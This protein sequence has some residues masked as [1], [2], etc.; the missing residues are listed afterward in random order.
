MNKNTLKK[1]GL[2]FLIATLI[3]LGFM[4]FMDVFLIAYDSSTYYENSFM[5]SNENGFSFAN[6][7]HFFRGF[8]YPFYVF[9]LRNLFELFS[10][11]SIDAFRVGNMLFLSFNLGVIF[12]MLFEEIFKKKFNLI[13]VAFLSVAMNLFYNGI[14]QQVL[15]DMFSI[16]TFAMAILVFLKLKNKMAKGANNYIIGI[17]SFFI[18]FLLYC[19]YNS[20]TI[21]LY[22]SILLIIVILIFA[23]KKIF[24]TSFLVI[25]VL[26]C[27]LPQIIVNYNATDQFSISPPVQNI[28]NSTENLNL[29]QFRTGI[30]MS[31]Y[32]T[33]V[34]DQSKGYQAGNVYYDQIGMDILERE[35]IEAFDSYSQLIGLYFKYPLDFIGIYTRNI[36]NFLDNRYGEIYIYDMDTPRTF[37]MFLNISI[38]YILAL[39]LYTQASKMKIDKCRLA[40]LTLICFPS[41]CTIPGAVEMRFFA[42]MFVVIYGFVGFGI[43]YNILFNYMMENKIKVT[44]LFIALTMILLTIWSMSFTVPNGGP[45]N[46]FQF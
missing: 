3:C 6:Y 2:A 27:A 18:G 45:I 10:L 29:F 4:I 15:S 42:P 9:M 38:L 8:L 17:S 32:Q 16:C 14:M 21:Y 7:P 34:G 11:S 36:V 24:I 43:N 19:A 40:A 35:G 22:A 44:L 28:G 31:R 25:G 20:R 23:K 30:M 1:Y 26:I 33:Y 5:F 46:L 41:I 39:G 37:K 12:P 13:Q